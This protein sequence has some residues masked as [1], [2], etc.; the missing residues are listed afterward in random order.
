MNGNF[1]PQQFLKTATTWPFLQEPIWRWF[2]FMLVI[3]FFASAQKGM[4]RHM[5]SIT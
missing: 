5:R 4:L 1:D 3:G 2:V